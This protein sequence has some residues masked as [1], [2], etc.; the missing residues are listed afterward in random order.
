MSDLVTR[1][2]DR[3]ER[4]TPMFTEAQ[5]QER[6]KELGAQISKDYEGESVVAIA[7]L[8]GSILFFSDLIRSMD[9]PG[10]EC[11][12]L[13]LSSYG[14]RTESSGVVRLTS[15]LSRAVEGKHLL[16]VED[17]VDTGLTVQYLLEN[18]GTRRPKS[19]KICTLL[20]KPAGT[21]VEV[22]MDYIG[23]TIENRFVV[24]YGLD[25]DERYRQLPF[26]GVMSFEDP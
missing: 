13:G 2:G 11:D 24:G 14:S 21:R 17:I 23:F 4:I 10:L 1:H 16:V 22:P 26:V 20:H 5:L 8:K 15:D 25:Y 6:I 18:L 9:L 7:V 12:F 19:I 3:I